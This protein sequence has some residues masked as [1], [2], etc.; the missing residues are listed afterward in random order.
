MLPNS[1]SLRDQR[2]ELILELREQRSIVEVLNV[3]FFLNVIPAFDSCTIMAVA[4]NSEW[5]HSGTSAFAGPG[6]DTNKLS[7]SDAMASDPNLL[8]IFGSQRQS[9]TDGLQLDDNHNG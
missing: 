4:R 9:R 2:C 1:G 8:R 6:R 7:S 3:V 5:T